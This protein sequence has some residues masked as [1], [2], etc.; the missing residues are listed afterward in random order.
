[1]SAKYYA[2]HFC[3]VNPSHVNG[4]TCEG[5]HNAKSSQAVVEQLHFVTRV[6]NLKI[7][8]QKFFPAKFISNT[9]EF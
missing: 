5:H 8:L 3:F 9:C 2:I 1:M 6:T 7:K 4:V